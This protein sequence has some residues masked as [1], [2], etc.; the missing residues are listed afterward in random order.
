MTATRLPCYV[1]EARNRRVVDDWRGE[2]FDLV[3][4]DTGEIVA[5][6]THGLFLGDAKGQVSTPGALWKV[7]HVPHG[8]PAHVAGEYH[9]NHSPL[10][11]RGETPTEDHWLVLT[12][13]GAFCCHCAASDGGLWTVTGDAPTLTVK[14]SIHQRPGVG[15]PHEWHGWLTNGE[16]HT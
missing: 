6:A 16:L 2:R 10:P 3:R 15:P 7:P 14:P 12:P 8:G 9:S 13:A 11:Y 5:E 4:V 1:V